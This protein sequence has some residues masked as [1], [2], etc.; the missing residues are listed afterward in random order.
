LTGI[1][2][3][4]G[5]LRQPSQDMPDN[6]RIMAPALLRAVFYLLGAFVV[7]FGLYGFEEQPG[8]GNH[9]L[10]YSTIGLLIVVPKGLQL[11]GG[12]ALVFD[13]INQR[14]GM[15]A[16]WARPRSDNPTGGPT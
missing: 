15:F 13:G 5:V 4:G 16:V 12:D 8:I 9:V 14:I 2:N 6:A 10:A 1:Q 11:P 7:F 3:G